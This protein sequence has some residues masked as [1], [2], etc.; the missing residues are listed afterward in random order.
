M[1]H[2]I[3]LHRSDCGTLETAQQYPPKRVANRHTESALQGTEHEPTVLIAMRSD[4]FD[5]IG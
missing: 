3:N 2:T 5:S 4:R 1:K